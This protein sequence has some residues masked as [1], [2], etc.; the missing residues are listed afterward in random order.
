MPA[1]D[2]DGLH[3]NLGII[4]IFSGIELSEVA[5]LAYRLQANL[6]PPQRTHC[7]M[8]HTYAKCANKMHKTLIYFHVKQTLKRLNVAQFKYTHR[9]V[10]T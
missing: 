3:H 9:A 2:Q 6:M 7:H 8:E 5:T 10:G 4:A 1:D